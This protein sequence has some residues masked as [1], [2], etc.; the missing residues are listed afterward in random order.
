VDRYALEHDGT[1]A[2]DDDEDTDADPEPEAV[3]TDGGYRGATDDDV[4]TAVENATDDDPTLVTDGGVPV[5]DED[6]DD[7][8][9]I[10]VRG[11]HDGVA[12]LSVYYRVGPT[13][14][15]ARLRPVRPLPEEDHIRD[16]EAL[17][18]SDLC[19]LDVPDLDGFAFVGP[20]AP[21]EEWFDTT[22]VPPVVRRA[23]DRPVQ[24]P[25]LGNVAGDPD[26]R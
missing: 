26:G 21:T 12:T 25:D 5:E 8:E 23:V 7:A 1:T 17:V 6:E 14:F 13:T 15:R 3:R 11:E 18:L 24:V 16:R 20:D 22:H 4:R 19:S 2:L 9:L 10:Q